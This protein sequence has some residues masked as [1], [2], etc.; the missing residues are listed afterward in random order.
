M[1]VLVDVY[2]LLEKNASKLK[3][4]HFCNYPVVWEVKEHAVDKP[5]T[6]YACGQHVDS[7]LYLVNAGR[8]TSSTVTK[9]NEETG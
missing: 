4:C 6:G 7:V 1:T 8:L 9:K 5:K 3:S 2:D